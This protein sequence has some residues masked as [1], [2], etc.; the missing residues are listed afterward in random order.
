MIRFTK[1]L[2][3]F[4]LFLY[5]LPLP[6]QNKNLFD[7]SHSLRFADYL[8]RTEQYE[9]AISEYERIVFMKPDDFGSRVKLL[10]SYRSLPDLQ[11]AYLKG[12]GWLQEMD[13]FPPELALEYGRILLLQKQFPVLDQF[14]MHPGIRLDSNERNSL[15]L[16]SLILQRQFDNA[17]MLLNDNMHH[18]PVSELQFFTQEIE[19]G[20]HLKQKSPLLAAGMS[21]VLPGS[22]RIYAGDWKDGL[23]SI[24]IIGSTGFGAYRAFLKEGKGS[25][26]AWI[27]SGLSF[28]FYLGNIYGSYQSARLNNIKKIQRFEKEVLHHISSDF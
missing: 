16:N 18:M 23:V 22:G 12:R 27:Y 1:H 13:T 2:L 5:G 25:A 14:L 4:L 20:R 24:L 9:L 3:F 7:Y 15:R 17:E 10:K 11:R 8:F 26:L 21:V 19:T 6:G 28:G